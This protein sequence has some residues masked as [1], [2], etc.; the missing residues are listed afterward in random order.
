MSNV[1]APY[2]PQDSLIRIYENAYTD[3]YCDKVIDCWESSVASEQ[4]EENHNWSDN[5]FRRDKAIFMDD[6]QDNDPQ[7]DL[8][9]EISNEFFSV[10]G[11][12]VN[13]YL[14]D[15]GIYRSVYC[16]ARNMKVQKYDHKKRGGFYKFHSE[17]SSS[18]G[19]VERLL[20]YTLYLNDVPAGEGET[21]FLY[22]GFRYEPK[23]GDLVV[24]PAAFTHTHRGNPV[25][26]TD[27]YIA[28]GW[29][30]WAE[31]PTKN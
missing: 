24:F 20:V 23:K 22:Q 5:T 9:V 28:T 18:P 12:N 4:E 21:E 17:C 19:Q 29:M 10:L 1:I 25:F 27:K 11:E 2:G 3:E 8:K 31:Q 6:I 26:T 15:T 7:E 30:M 16:E 14:N 13:S